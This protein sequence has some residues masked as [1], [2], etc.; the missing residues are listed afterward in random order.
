LDLYLDSSAIAKATLDEP[1]GVELRA[2]MDTSERVATCRVAYAEVFAALARARRE[3]RLAD[4]SYR[5]VRA[6]F[7][8]QWPTFF[9]VDVDQQLVENAAGLLERHALRGFDALHLA[10]ALEFEREATFAC[11]DARLWSAAAGLGFPMI[12]KAAP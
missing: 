8:R 1:G 4:A 10:A 11:W 3:G 12:P 6:D 7:R 9:I 5:S 2:A